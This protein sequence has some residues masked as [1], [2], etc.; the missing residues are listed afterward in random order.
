MNG[1]R[2]GRK[3]RQRQQEAIAQRSISFVQDRCCLMLIHYNVNKYFES[4]TFDRLDFESLHWQRN[5]YGRSTLS[6]KRSNNRTMCSW[7]G[8]HSCDLYDYLVYRIMGQLKTKGPSCHNFWSILGFVYH[9]QSG[10]VAEPC[11]LFMNWSFRQC[12]QYQQIFD[13]APKHWYPGL[14]TK[15]LVAGI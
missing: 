2:I 15:L 7:T 5:S 10:C 12:R 13:G 4:L 14:K 8:R 9:Q 6:K 11:M 1:M 3:A